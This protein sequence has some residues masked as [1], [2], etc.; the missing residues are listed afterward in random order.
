[1]NNPLFIPLFLQAPI[2]D[3]ASVKAGDW[4]T[5]ELVEE[6]NDHF[7]GPDDIG[8]D[9]GE[10]NKE[11]F[12]EHARVL[13]PLGCQ[14]ASY[15]QLKGA[16]NMF[17][18]AWGASGSMGSSKIACAYGKPY[19]A[20]KPLSVAPGKQRS[21][22]PSLKATKCPFKISYSLM[23]VDIHK[24]KPNIQYHVRITSVNYHHSCLLA[25]ETLWLTL[26][27]GGKLLPNLAGLQDVLMLLKEHPQIDC[28]VI[29]SLLQK[30][31]PFYQSI[32]GAY[33]RNFRLPAFNYIDTGH[34]LTMA[35]AKALTLKNTSTADES[36][37][38][39]NPIFPRIS[40]RCSR[41][42]CKMTQLHDKQLITSK[43]Y[44]KRFPALTSGSSMTV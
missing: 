8:G 15:I 43:H 32:D 14:F 41:R 3:F 1:M 7:P 9:N 27:A 16:V 38:F 19:K 30:Y 33:I 25:P 21:H 18:Q 13:F 12:A 31:V 36:V 17:L 44:T 24:K 28:K 39:D 20:S 5:A 42:P 22:G 2:P 26:K 11:S 10:R 23:H 40:R 34:E 4:L 6:I 35:E 37:S 29:H